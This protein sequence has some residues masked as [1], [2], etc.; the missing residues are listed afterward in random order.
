MTG[1]KNI[2]FFFLLAF[3]FAVLSCSKNDNE[4]VLEPF[5]N[6][7]LSPVIEWALVTD[8]Y[9]ACHEKAG[10]E[11][12]SVASFRRGEVYQV[13]GNCTVYITDGETSPSKRE[14][15]KKETWYAIEN[16]WVPSSSV[17]IFS[18][19]LRALSALKE[20]E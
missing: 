18:N 17:K 8:P 9:V 10:Y 11:Y 4:I 5:D 16:G 1:C 14:N 6:G 15:A 13:E 20:M 2:I 12:P 3:S 7:E 19:K